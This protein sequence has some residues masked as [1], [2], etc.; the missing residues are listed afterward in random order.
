LG[1][2]TFSLEEDPI[3]QSPEPDD[4]AGDEPETDLNQDPPPEDDREDETADEEN[5]FGE[6]NSPEELLQAYRALEQLVHER[7]QEVEHLTIGLNEYG[8]HAKARFREAQEQVFLDK[9]RDVYD[10]DPVSATALMIKKFQ[11]DALTDYDGRMQRQLQQHQDFNRF[12]NDFFAQPENAELKPHRNEVEFLVREQGVPPE[13]A[14]QVVR[15]VAGKNHNVSARREAAARAVRNRSMVENAGEV[16]EPTPK[17]REF[18]RI[19]KTSKTLDEMFNG[20]GKI[21]L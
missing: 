20:L 10:H 16:G 2:S 7:A 6:F 15:T 13:T 19:L 18:D 3:M 12:M 21:R 4:Q 11:E 1:R 17:D 9:I 8:H 5:P 14:A